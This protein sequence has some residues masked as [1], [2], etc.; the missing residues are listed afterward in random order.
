MDAIRGKHLKVRDLLM[1]HGAIFS[2][3]D[4]EKYGQELCQAAAAGKFERVVDLVN[5]GA[6]VNST[7]FDKRTPLHVAAAEGRLDVVEFLLSMKADVHSKDRW[8]G[9]PLKDAIRGNHKRVQEVLKAHGALGLADE[10]SDHGQTIGEKMCASACKGDLNEIKS[11]FAKRASVNAADYDKRSALH[12]AA[13]EGHEEVVKFLVEMK[14]EVNAKD[15]WGGDPLKDAIRGG[16]SACQLILRDAGGRGEYD[17]H[18]DHKDHGDRMCNA[19]SKGDYTLIVN[20]VARNASVNAADYDGRSALHLA[21]AEGHDKIVQFLVDKKADVKVKDRWGGDPLKDAV[22]SGHRKVQAILLA[23]GA[24]KDASDI[25]RAKE[26][27][28]LD[29]S[30]L[31]FFLS[32]FDVFFRCC[33]CVCGFWSCLNDWRAFF[34]IWNFLLCARPHVCV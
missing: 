15:R 32:V 3:E 11:L 9:D 4:L 6:C 27:L 23:A 14:A 34:L 10:H 7:D 5:I 33:S 30:V 26:Q 20:L 29:R 1:K 17:D 18:S 31:C 28:E 25:D 24:G 13:A 12:L 2:K 22:R 19:A 8:G 16:H 21:S